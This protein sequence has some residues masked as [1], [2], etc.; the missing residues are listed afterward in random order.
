M[1]LCDAASCREWSSA[2]L[3]DR[4]AVAIGIGLVVI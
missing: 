3:A 4:Y 1:P 2:G